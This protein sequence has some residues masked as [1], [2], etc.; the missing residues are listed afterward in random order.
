MNKIHKTLLFILVLILMLIQFGCSP[1][2]LLTELRKPDISV[3][4]TLIEYTQ[5]DNSDFVQMESMLRSAEKRARKSEFMKNISENIYLLVDNEIAFTV[6]IDGQD[7][8]VTRGK[9][10]DVSPTLLIPFTA[11]IA[12]NVNDVL[13]DFMLDQAEVFNVCHVVFMPCLTRM[14]S[15]PYLFDTNMFKGKLDN[16]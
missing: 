6:T 16:Y 7:V 2:R 15:M 5:F 13:E 11:S 12:K 4:E 14:Y 3:E 8:V 9:R 10:M 1:G